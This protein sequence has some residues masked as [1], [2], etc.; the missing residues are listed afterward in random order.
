[1]ETN[2]VKKS[3]IFSKFWFFLVFIFLV[4]IIPVIGATFWVKWNF[5]APAKV[6]KEQ[7]FVIKE[8]ES[9]QSIAN[10]LKQEGLI[11]DSLAFRIYARI[12]CKGVN[13][14]NPLSLLKSYPSKDC[15]SGKIQAGTFKLSPTMDLATLSINLTKGKVDSWTR[16]IEGLRNEEVAEK[17]AK[18]YPFKVEDFLNIAKIGYMFPDTYLFKVNSTAEEISQKMQV[19]FN[20]KFDNSLQEKVKAQGLTPEEGVILAS[21][22]Q[23]EAGKEGDAAL[24]ASV[25]LNRLNINMALGSDVTIQ[26]ALGYDTEGKTWWK[27]DLT[28]QDL[29]IVSP[30]NTRKVA[31]LP[32]GAICN[33]G[34]AA[35][36]AVAEPATSDYYYFLYDKEGKL[37]LARTLT[38]HNANKSKYLQ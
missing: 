9:T 4:I 36:K 25:F 19:T 38:E 1:M 16:L 28:D 29:A 11:R 18:Q 23:R 30:Y 6:G 15:L 26:Y 27:K 3:K 31:G 10:R 8:N 12:D 34:L 32:P 21:I 14:A 17:L 20:E 37:H 5:A 2:W 24:I 7:I 35:L 13:F 22:V 33:P